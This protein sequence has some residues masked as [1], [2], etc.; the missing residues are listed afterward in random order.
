MDS[1]NLSFV[2]QAELVTAILGKS[3][4]LVYALLATHPLHL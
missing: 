1:L 3:Y 4:A 2:A